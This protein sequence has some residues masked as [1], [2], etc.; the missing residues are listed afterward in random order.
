MKHLLFFILLVITLTPSYYSKAQ[1]M[2]IGTNFWA[3]IDWTNELPFKSDINF[4]QTWNSGISDF[5]VSENIWEEEFLNEIGFYTVLRFMDWLPTNNSPVTNWSQRR[6]PTDAD[7]IA[8][9][10]AEKGVAFEWMIDLCNR[11]NADI[12]LCMPHAA[13]DDYHVQLATLL[14]NNLK[15]ELKI[16]IEYSNE[17]WNFD[18][19]KNYAQEQG[20]K[21][22]LSGQEFVA[23]RSAQIWQI[24]ATVFG[25]Q[26]EKR[27]VKTICGQAAN[28]WIA[29][30]QLEYLYSTSNPTGLIPDAYG[31]APYF[32]GNGLDANDPNIW[33]LLDTDIFEHRWDSSDKDSRLEGVI[34]NH[35]TIKSF[36]ANLDLVAYE[37]GQ[38]LVKNATKV[39]YH[40]N[41]YDVYTKYLEAMDDYITVFSHYVNAGECS[42]GGCWGAKDF[43]GQDMEYAPKYRALYNYAE[44]HPTS[45][46]SNNSKNQNLKIYPVPLKEQLT[47]QLETPEINSVSIYSVFGEKI[48]E[49][50]SEFPLSKMNIKTENL[51]PGFYILSVTTTN[52]LFIREVI[53]KI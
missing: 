49:I 9:F 38:H 2:E 48:N 15:P 20:T 24:F 1:S 4:E 27:L 30:E 23:H 22:G 19:Q 29:N 44:N 43:T 16:Y 37:G 25:D 13:D 3:R 34:K 33:Q 47:V 31:I 36:D 17:V 28:N 46:R 8:K 10:N 42:D 32:G 6:L 11:I 52:N 51:S 14:F 7:Q 45:I 5:L 41:M 18:T 39:N 26:F 50:R 21:L 35:Q 12:W 53:S 40:E